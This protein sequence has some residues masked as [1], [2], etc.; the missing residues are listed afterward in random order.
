VKLNALKV[1]LVLVAAVLTVAVA[2]AG[3]VL[4]LVAAVW[5]LL[6]VYVQIAFAVPPVTYAMEAAV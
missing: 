4:L 6:A 2:T 1:V 3:L 5:A